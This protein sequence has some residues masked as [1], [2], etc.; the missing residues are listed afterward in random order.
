MAHNNLLSCS[1]ALV[2]QDLYTSIDNL[3]GTALCRYEDVA[4]ADHDDGY[5]DVPGNDAGVG[6][7]DKHRYM[8]VP[9]GFHSINDGLYTVRNISQRCVE[10]T[11]L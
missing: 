7:G 8:E 5:V 11:L 4:P 3:S 10:F 2:K 6:D 1:N 9:G